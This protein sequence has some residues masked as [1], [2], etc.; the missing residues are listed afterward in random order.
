MTGAPFDMSPG[1]IDMQ[2]FPMGQAS[3]FMMQNLLKMPLINQLGDPSALQRL[4]MDPTGPAAPSTISGHHSSTIP[5]QN[6]I[7]SQ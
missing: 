2:K 4:N 3:P 7:S 5:G 1:K 6:N